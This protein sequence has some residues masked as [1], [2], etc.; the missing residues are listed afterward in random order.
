MAYGSTSIIENMGTVFVIWEVFFI[1]VALVQLTRV[2]CCGLSRFEVFKKFFEK[3]DKNLYWGAFLR[4]GLE[5]YIESAIAAQIN[6]RNFN[7]ENYF[8]KE[9]TL[10]DWVSYVY[11]IILSIYLVVFPVFTL[12]FLFKNKSV[13]NKE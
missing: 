8:D 13:I 7:D 9:S 5:I 3:M 4:F 2:L 12:V 11:A 6:I 1:Y 10:H